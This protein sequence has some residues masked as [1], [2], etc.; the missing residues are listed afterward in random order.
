[1]T[2]DLS[3]VFPPICTPFTTD[4]EVD[5]PMLK[6]NLRRYITQP[7]R[8]IVVIGSNGESVYLNKKERYAIIQETAK[9]LKT[10][11]KKPMLVIAGTGAQSTKETI[12]YTKDAAE[13]GADVALVVTPGFFS[14]SQQAMESYFRDV[15]DASPI[16]I[17]L[18]IVP[19]FSGVE[20]PPDVAIRLASH[21]K[22][23][24][25]KDSSANIASI[26]RIIHET[27]GQDF[28]VLAGSAT[29]FLPSL[30]MGAV[31]GVLALANF[32]GPQCAELFSLF[33]KSDKKKAVE[34]QGKLLNLNNAVNAFGVAGLKYTLDRIG[35]YGGP[36]RKPLRDLDQSDK[37]R[38]EAI[39][40]KYQLVTPKSKL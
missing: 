11:A 25:Y 26:T 18:Y 21:P 23:I 7:L 9:I 10:E 4:G 29:F 32:A 22:I 16:P 2:V 8:G 34:L 31:G 35:F 6:S 30:V 38:L 19:K 28:Q 36:V 37:A 12:E 24:G 33:Q 27:Q 40:V 14:L 5:I 39:L 20:L 17:M 15:A 3:G 13:A 1:M